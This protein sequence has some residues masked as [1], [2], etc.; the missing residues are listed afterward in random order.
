MTDAPDDRGASRSRRSA[1]PRRCGCGRAGRRSRGCREE[2]SSALAR[3]RALGI[4][5]A[6]FFALKPQHQTTGPNSTTPTTATRR[7]AWRTCRGLHR[8]AAS[9]AAA[10]AAAARRSRPA[11]PECRRA[12]A[13]HADRQ[14]RS[15]AA[16]HRAGAGSSAD[17]PSLRDDQLSARPPPAPAPTPAGACMPLAAKRA[18][19]D[20]TL[21]GSQARLPERQRRSAHHQPRSRRSRRP[22]HTSCRRAP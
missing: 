7:T 4:G 6:L 2:C 9:R 18:S 12:R 14:R 16:A 10:R 15:R 5:G 17:Q 19:T 22:A 21:A 1:R 11:D 8:P 20:L 3:R 13:R